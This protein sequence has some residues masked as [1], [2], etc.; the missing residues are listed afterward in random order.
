MKVMK[1]S[2]TSESKS[3]TEIALKG[4]EQRYRT[5]MM[6]IGD[7][8]IATDYEGRV[9]MMN[10]VAEELTGWKQEEALGKLLEKIF[11]IVNEETRKTVENPVRHVMREGMVVG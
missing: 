5:I 10:P 1:K 6:S 7:G 4:S 9:E 2:N 3:K 8:V 11:P